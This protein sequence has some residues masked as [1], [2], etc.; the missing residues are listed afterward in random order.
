MIMKF[1][2]VSYIAQQRDIDKILKQFNQSSHLYFKE[3]E[4]VNSKQKWNLMLCRQEKCD[5]YFYEG[6]LPVEIISYETV[7]EGTHLS[8]DME[9]RIIYAKSNDISVCANILKC[10]GTT[11]FEDN[12]LL[13]CNLRGIFDK[14]DFWLVVS[15]T[16]EMK[17]VYLDD[18]GFGC[19]TFLVDR[20]E[21]VRNALRNVEGIDCITESEVL[22]VNNR[23]LEVCFLRLSALNVIFEFITPVRHT[24]SGSC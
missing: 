2:H 15:L 13:K 18:K 14:E 16:E 19:I 8:V 7:F 12:G 22:I 5:M 4:K 20:M 10:I 9:H 3:I 23:K 1:D 11:L 17:T 24:N 21:V 6:Q